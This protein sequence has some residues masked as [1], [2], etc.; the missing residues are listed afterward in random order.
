MAE[1]GGWP[2]GDEGQSYN[3]KKLNSAKSIAVGKDSEPQ[4]AVV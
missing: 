2:L 1:N 4:V 3:Y